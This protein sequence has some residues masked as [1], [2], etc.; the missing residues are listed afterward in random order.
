VAFHPHNTNGKAFASFRI[1][2]NDWPTHPKILRCL[3]HSNSALDSARRVNA[4]QG[5][6]EEQCFEQS[7]TE[8][9]SVDFVLIKSTINKSFVYTNLPTETKPSQLNLSFFL[10]HQGLMQNGVL[11]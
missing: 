8:R 2:T 11:Y 10:F 5:W 4:W 1:L 6:L 7:E 9:A 3:V